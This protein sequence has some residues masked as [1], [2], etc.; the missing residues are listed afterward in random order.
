VEVLFVTGANPMRGGGGLES[1]VRAHALAA[2]AA[3]FEVHVFCLGR[4][5]RISREGFG[6]VHQIA[7][8]PHTIRSAHAGL[9][10]PLVARALD[11]HVQHAG[12]VLIHAF[13]A[14]SCGAAWYCARRGLPTTLVTSAYATQAQEMAAILGGL[15]REHGA[16]NALRYLA[17]YA[18]ART[19]G[20]WGERQGYDGSRLL[21]VNYESVR[22]LLRDQ[23]AAD[24]EI[25]MMPYASDLAFTSASASAD[26][27]GADTEPE[28]IASLEP[29]DAPLI[30]SVSRHDARKG[31]DVLLHSLASL[32]TS[33]VPFRACLLGRGELIEAHRR[34]ADRLGLGRSV[35]IPGQVPEV[36]AY[37]R[38]AD[39]YV[40][41]S[42][43]E[44]SGSV[45]LLEALQAGNAIVTSGCD[46]I[47]EDVSDGESALVVAPGDARA[48]ARAIEHLLGDEAL[49][50]RLGANAMALYER[51]FS[52][53]RFTDSLAALYA[54][55]GFTPRS[56]A[57]A[58]S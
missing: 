6:S 11:R 12:P 18:I 32:R 51:R 2:C 54:E 15:R 34:L 22:A 45:S 56:E 13:G 10:S 36:L 9:Y 29:T 58:S 43:S 27:D 55:L 28:L 4:E 16:V 21:L 5:R 35:A 48:L 26:Q 46:G 30:V 52:A 1:Y 14:H 17:R 44:A 23:F 57:S 40:L 20:S 8:P 33:G 50:V 53:E 38:R 7:T 41:P 31:V 3:G 47:P 24:W 49:R 25:R 37:L 39:V 42:L 19:I